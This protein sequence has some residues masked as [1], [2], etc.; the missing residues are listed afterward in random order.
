[1]STGVVGRIEAT[2][3]GPSNR[4]A[5]RAVRT[6]RLAGSRTPFASAATLVLPATILMLA[7]LVAPIALLV[8]YPSTSIARRS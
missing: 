7:I 1:M 4:V 3:S 5:E 2:P 6:S 8:R